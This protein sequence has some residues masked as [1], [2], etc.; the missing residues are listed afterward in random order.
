MRGE[1]WLA[2]YVAGFLVLAGPVIG[3]QPAST[4]A[5][6][7]GCTMATLEAFAASVIEPC[8]Q[9]LANPKLGKKRRAELMFLLGRGYH[10]TS[11]LAQAIS[12]YDEA[13]ALDAGSAELLTSRAWAAETAD[14]LTGAQTFIE[15]ALAIDPKNARAWDVVGFLRYRN[16]DVEGALDAYS[17]AIELDPQLGLPRLHR[18]DLRAMLGH[19]LD[20]ISDLG[21]ILAIPRQRIDR[22]GLLTDDGQVASFHAAAYRRRADIY[23]RTK[24][25]E[26]A[27]ADYSAAIAI[28]P[29]VEY[30]E[31]RGLFLK[32]QKGRAEDALRDFAAARV[33]EPN[34]LRLW[35]HEADSLT[36]ANR[37]DEA[38]NRY[39]EVLARTPDYGPA[40]RGRI[41]VFRGSKRFDEAARE[42]EEWFNADSR[43]LFG[44]IERM[45]IRGYWHGER[46]PERVTPELRKAFLNCV[47]DAACG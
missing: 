3:E 29:R 1:Y 10:R 14:D 24:R 36:W 30:L 37:N 47:Q 41:A 15:R 46:F 44:L 42:L 18:A 21:S 9:A 43:Q 2:V 45:V 12:T 39:A 19:H 31:A 7:K 25:F 22:G 38:L 27:E 33:I 34:N 8:Q 17:R 11:R 5:G 4:A 40:R 16:R 26:V 35:V 23:A 20:A 13:L 32:R 6:A 28:E